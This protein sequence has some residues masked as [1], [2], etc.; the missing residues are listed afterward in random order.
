M[1]NMKDLAALKQ[2]GALAP[3]MIVDL[4]AKAMHL[5]RFEFIV[6]L[7]TLN[8]PII[9]LSIYWEEG[10]EF[11]RIPTV[12]DVQRKLVYASEP[13]VS[14]FF[15]DMTLLCYAFDAEAKTR[16]HAELDRMAGVIGDYSRNAAQG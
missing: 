4:R 16:V 1:M 3:Q 14:G 10:R 2:G 6:R 13:H 8:T 12:E 11:M 7:L 15:D 9:T 5:V